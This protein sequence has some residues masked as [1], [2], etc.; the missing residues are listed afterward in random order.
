ME[1]SS[2][3]I[4][5][6]E[7]ILIK[8]KTGSGKSTLIDLILGFQNPI[9]GKIIVDKGA[10]DALNRGASL[11]PAGIISVIGTFYKGD[12]VNVLNKKKIVICKGISAYPSKD[13]RIIAGSKSNEIESLLGYH[14]RD[15]I[16]HRDDMVLKN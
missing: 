6:G 15:V 3:K 14:F 16:I 13:A 5:K 11:L 4:N 9:S 10:E 12:I 7:K 1:N 8:G 2:L